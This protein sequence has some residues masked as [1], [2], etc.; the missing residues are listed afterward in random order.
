M[1][2]PYQN[3]SQPLGDGGAKDFK[4]A[5][6]LSAVSV[7]LSIF[8]TLGSLTCALIAL[9]A[10]RR[11]QD[12]GHPSGSIAFVISIGALVLSIG[13]RILRFGSHF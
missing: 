13:V 4:L 3:Y 9:R 11:A 12:L 6:T 1:Y 7:L 2:Q 8:F 5:L 10:S